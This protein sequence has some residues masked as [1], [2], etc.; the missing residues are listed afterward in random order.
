[1]SRQGTDKGKRAIRNSIGPGSYASIFERA[2]FVRVHCVSMR[3]SV[4]H[5]AVD[6]TDARCARLKGVVCVR[7]PAYRAGPNAGRPS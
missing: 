5:T 2:R 4:R 3:A 1:V 7:P 6:V